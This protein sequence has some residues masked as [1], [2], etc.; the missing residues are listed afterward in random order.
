M[1]QK[2]GSPAPARTPRRGAR[3]DTAHLAP[4]SFGLAQL[5]VLLVAGCVAAVAALSIAVNRA[6]LPSATGPAVEDVQVGPITIPVSRELPSPELIAVSLVGLVGVAVAAVTLEVIATLLLSVRPRRRTLSALRGSPDVAPTPGTR[7]RVVAVV[8]AHNEE[9]VIAA[10][11][12]SLAAQSRPPDHTIVIADNCTD[13]T[14]E[15]AH[16][17]GAEVFPTVG[18][19]HK[20]A[21]GLNQLLNVLLRDA[22]AGDAVLVLDAD[23]VL[24]PD[25]IATA[26]GR[27]ESDPELAAVGATF[28]G[29]EGHGLLGQFQRNEFTRYSLQVRARR[30]RV[31]VL[32]GTA[33]LFRADALL[34]VAAARGVLIPGESG[35]VYDTAALT[36]DN[37]LTL[38]LKSIGADMTSPDECTVVTEIMPDVPS[39]WRQRRR[40]QRGALEN[41]NAYG[42]TWG[43]A[44]YWGQQFGIGYGVLSLNSA[45]LLLALTVLAAGQWVWFPFWMAITGVFVVE[46]V[47]TAWRGGWRARVLAALLVPEICYDLFLQAVFVVS[48]FEIMTNR[49]AVW[50][51]SQKA[52]T[53]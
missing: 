52:V 2:A 33:S 38:A 46:R 50:G 19:V 13:R 49:R 23:T 6:L 1:T 40:W 53:A 45:L 27:L 11:L 16:D 20:K 29:G 35:R 21:G 15:I 44:R 48:L 47:A 32:T 37:E 18:N 30:G 12:A 10:T 22:T 42:I 39:L 34:D 51:H 5:V 26:S 31:F 4:D 41:L 8:P 24:S 7:L 28:T 36:E 14:A 9:D 43:T 3:R 25:F 17:C